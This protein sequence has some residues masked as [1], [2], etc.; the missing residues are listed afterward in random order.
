[1]VSTLQQKL[2]VSESQMKSLTDRLESEREEQKQF[3]GSLQNK[4]LQLKT[5]VDEL[6]VKVV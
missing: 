6:T 4:E 5:Q 1:M 3:T 2:E